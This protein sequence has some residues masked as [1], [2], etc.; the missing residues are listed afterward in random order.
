MYN[1]AVENLLSVSQTTS[2]KMFTVSIIILIM[3]E[4]ILPVP[5]CT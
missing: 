5:P 1:L 4:K 2:M 3:C